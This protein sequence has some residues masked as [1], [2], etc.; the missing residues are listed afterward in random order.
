MLTEIGQSLL[1]L[2]VC[3]PSRFISPIYETLLHPASFSNCRIRRISEG[4]ACPQF[5][6]ELLNYELACYF[7]SSP[8]GLLWLEPLRPWLKTSWC[9]SR[10]CCIRVG[11]WLLG[12]RTGLGKLLSTLSR[13]KS[14]LLLSRT[15]LG[16]LLSL[17]S[18]KR[19]RN[20][21]LVGLLAN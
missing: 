17:R 4:S 2:L 7:R 16:S 5:A 15:P 12:F 8:L 18:A 19:E 9:R 14:L 3:H 13:S 20:R 21:P 1:H 11:L 10:I 6:R